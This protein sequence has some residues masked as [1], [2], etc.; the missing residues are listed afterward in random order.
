[1]MMVGACLSFWQ[2]GL[3]A[4][5]CTSLVE[6]FAPFPFVPHEGIPRMIL[7]FAAYFGAGL[8]VFEST[9]RRQLALRHLQE[10]ERE[11]VLRREAEEQLKVLVESSPAAIFTLD[12]DGRVLLANQAPYHLLAFE[13]ENLIGA[14]MEKY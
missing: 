11:I 13:G 6:S 12:G 4:V 14:P 7:E 3:A 5:V 10:I 2:I 8:F 1:M 9:K